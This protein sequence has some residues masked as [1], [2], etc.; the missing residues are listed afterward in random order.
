MI[1]MIWVLA[2]HALVGTVPMAPVLLAVAAACLLFPLPPLFRINL[3]LSKRLKHANKDDASL[4]R[5]CVRFVLI[6]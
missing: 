5:K 4:A 1:K 6:K 2:W 3:V